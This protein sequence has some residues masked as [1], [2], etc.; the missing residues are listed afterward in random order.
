MAK[1]YQVIYENFA[2]RLIDTMMISDENLNAMMTSYSDLVVEMAGY[3]GFLGNTKHMKHMDRADVI[4]EIRQQMEEGNYG[5]AITM[6][7]GIAADTPIYGYYVT[8]E[9]ELY[10]EG[11][12]HFFTFDAKKMR[13]Y[14]DDLMKRVVNYAKLPYKHTGMSQW[15]LKKK[16][17]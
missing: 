1:E 10:W 16:V 6:M 14:L 4:E 8:K 17:E 12:L 2:K 5:D 7:C 15:E 9:R 13:R 3:L 11:E